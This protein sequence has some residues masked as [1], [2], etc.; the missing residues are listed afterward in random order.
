M[1]IKSTI[2]FLTLILCLCACTNNTNKTTTLDIVVIPPVSEQW[3]CQIDGGDKI[4]FTTDSSGKTKVELTVDSTK[5]VL[6]FNPV[7]Q[8]VAETWIEPGEQCVIALNCAAPDLEQQISTTGVY[9][10]RTM[11]VY[12]ESFG[13]FYQ[14]LANDNF[15]VEL[16]GDEDNYTEFLINR[17]QEHMDSLNSHPEW[18]S[19]VRKEALRTLNNNLI[20]RIEDPS[21]WLHFCAELRGYSESVSPTVIY[22]KNKHK[23]YDFMGKKQTEYRQ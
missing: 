11:A 22:Q 19:Y 9:K 12:S 21:F 2:L 10:E 8:F 14:L 5:H 3:V 23:V 16:S 7:T 17:Y 18:P 13:Y 20:D 15:Y 4:N 6:F 1:N